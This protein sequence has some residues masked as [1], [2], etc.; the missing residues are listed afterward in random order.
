MVMFVCPAY[1]SYAEMMKGAALAQHADFYEVV[2]S[3]SGG[4]TAKGIV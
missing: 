2:I 1:L 3:V 4:Q